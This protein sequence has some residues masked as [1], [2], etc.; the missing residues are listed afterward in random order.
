MKIGFDAKRALNNSAGLGNYSRNL[1][2][3]LM[4]HFAGNDYLLFSPKAKD[5]F[6]NQLAGEF[7]IVFPEGKLNQSFHSLWRSFGVKND[8]LKNRMDIYHGLS[9]EIPFGIATTMG[10]VVTIHDLIFLNHTEQ[11]P[12]VDRQIYTLKTRYAARHAHK[13]IAVSNQTKKDLME[14]YGVPEKKIEVIYPIIDAAFQRTESRNQ[15]SDVLQK[16]KLPGKYILNVGSFFARKNQQTL[17]EAFDLIKTQ[18]QENLVLVGGAGNM[19]AEIEALIIKKGLQNR[20]HII[21]NVS[22]ADLP[23]VYSAASAFVFPSLYEGFGMPIAEALLSGVPVI[24][25]SGGCFE[26]AGG[27]NSLYINPHSPDEIGAALL[28]VLGNSSFKHEMIE[29]GFS[30]AQTM[31]AKIMAQK[32]MAVYNSL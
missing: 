13:I 27:K 14:L 20:V 30:H 18:V 6:L 31:S 7:K 24:A 29:S 15:K 26:E 21:A 4:Q 16:Y 1:I 8:L 9:N 25:T 32:T 12:F 3:A 19:R 17:I 28:K 5:E 11:Y 2:N 23:D 10:T 22:N